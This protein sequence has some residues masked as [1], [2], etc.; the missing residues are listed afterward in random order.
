MLGYLYRQTGGAGIVAAPR[1]GMSSVSDEIAAVAR[2]AGADIRTNSEVSRIVVG[3][4]RVPGVEL[5]D[6][7]RFDSLTVVSNAA[8][9]TTLLQL[10][11][12]RHLETGFARRIANFRAS[13][14]VAKLHLA[15]DGLPE[16]PGLDPGLLGDRLLVAGS[17]DELEMAFNPAKYG[18]FSASPAIEVCLP[19]VRDEQ[20]APAGRH[21]L[22]AVVQ[23]AP[24]ALRGGW[25]ES[26]RRDFEAGA[27]RVLETVMPD[28][29]GR[30]VAS[31]LLTPVDLQGEFRLH[32]GHWHHGE[33]ALDQFLF[34]RPVAGA[35]QYRM[36]L[37]GLYLCG[38]G[39]HPGGGVSGAP[40]RNAARAVQSDE[41]AR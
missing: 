31:E 38:A 8:P 28:I 23:Y 2:A 26:A 7:E 37:D 17:D 6:G 19:S 3:N 30:I 29:A 13:G 32:G 11:G 25:T 33:L 24:F 40:G 4:G 9:K 21:V 15:L 14:N 34:V 27:I 20:L 10:V 1:G 5:V 35:S 36:P 39:A 18:E 22:S 41:D 16:V 12:A